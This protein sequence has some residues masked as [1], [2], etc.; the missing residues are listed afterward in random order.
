V[1]VDGAELDQL[2]RLERLDEALA[3]VVWQAGER[4]LVGRE[5]LQHGLEGDAKGAPVDRAVWRLHGQRRLLDLEPDDA[6]AVEVATTAEALDL[7]Q[8]A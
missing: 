1:L 7:P 2:H 8:L 3:A 5:L 6:L 4:R